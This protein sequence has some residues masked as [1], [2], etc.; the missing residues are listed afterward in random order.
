MCTQSLGKLVQISQCEKFYLR[1]L[2]ASYL[3]IIVLQSLCRTCLSLF[4]NLK[5]LV[6]QSKKS[7]TEKT[8]D[9]SSNLMEEKM[10]A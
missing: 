8:Q 1:L 10:P 3:I 6:F 2:K 5:T 7:T 4:H 9:L